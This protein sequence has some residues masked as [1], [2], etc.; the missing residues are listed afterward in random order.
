MASSKEPPLRS[1][2]LQKNNYPL[3][4]YTY[5]TRNRDLQQFHP[6]MK[7]EAAEPQDLAINLCGDPAKSRPDV[8]PYILTRFASLAA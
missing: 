7:K 4:N 5:M 1:Q 6:Q 2:N 8:G 3:L